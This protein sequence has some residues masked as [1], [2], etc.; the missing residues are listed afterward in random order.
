MTAQAPTGAILLGVVIFCDYLVVKS[1]ITGRS[2]LTIGVGLGYDFERRN[3]PVG[4]W[5]STAVNVVF[6][7]FSTL[8]LGRMAFVMMGLAKL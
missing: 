5:C 6:C 4:Y 3:S 7:A 2:R 1:L 8:G